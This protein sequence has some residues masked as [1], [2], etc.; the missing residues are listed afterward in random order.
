MNIS[1]LGWHLAHNRMCLIE[2]ALLSTHTMFRPQWS[3]YWREAEKYYSTLDVNGRIVYDVGCDYGTTPM[4]FSRSGRSLNVAIPVSLK[5]GFFSGDTYNPECAFAQ[6]VH[7]RRAIIT[8]HVVD[9]APIHVERR[10][11]FFRFS[12]IWRPLGAKHGMG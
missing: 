5:Y 3:P 2:D 11:V 8:T 12:P 9:Y 1:K 10:V 7:R 6:E 4:Y